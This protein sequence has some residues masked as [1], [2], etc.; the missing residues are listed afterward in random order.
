MDYSNVSRITI[1]QSPLK[2]LH[3]LKLVVNWVFLFSSDEPSL[4]LYQALKYKIYASVQRLFLN[5]QG[6]GMNP[7]V[8]STH[9]F[10]EVVLLNNSSYK[11]F[12]SKGRILSSTWLE[13]FTN[14]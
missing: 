7:M 4:Q 14:V 10:I 1:Y 9:L 6:T 11:D 12:K 2:S 13:S 3:I 5:Y 8:E